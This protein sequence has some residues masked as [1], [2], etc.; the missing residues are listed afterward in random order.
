MGDIEKRIT[1]K[2]ILDSTGFNSSIKGVNSELKN[3]QSALKLASSSLQTFG[4]DSEKLKSVQEALSKQIELQSKKIDIYKQ[5][6]EKSTSK[7]QENVAQRDKLK[8]AIDMEKAKLESA[9]QV[10]G[11]EN[12]VVT[13]LKEK[14]NT[15]TQEY[16]KADKAVESN[17]KSIQSYDTNLNKASTEMVKAQGELKKVNS[18][19]SEQNNK[20]LNSSKSLKEHS[21]G[22]KK[23]G[24]GA[25]SAGDKV[26]KLTLPL[27]AVGAAA[28][29][30]GMDFDA[31]MSRVKAISGATGEEFEKLK[32]QAI[33]LGGST[34]FSAKEAASGMENLASAGFSTSEIMSAMPGMLDL[35]AS[36]GEDLAS[37]ADIAASTLRGFGLEANQAGH[38]ADVL[39]KNAG[40]TNAAVK[41]TGEAMKY[42]APAAKSMGLGLEEVTAAIG[43]MANSGIKGSEAGTTLRGALT[44]LASPSKEAA[45]AMKDMKFEA[46]DAQGKLYSLKDLVSKL[47]VSMKGMTDQK[48]ADTIATIFGQE[49]MSGMLTL[50]EDGPEALDTLTQSYK[51]SDGAASDMAKTMQD[52]AKSSIEQMFGS[53]ET[54]GI[55]LEESFAPTITKVAETIGDLADKFSQLSPETQDGIVKMVAFGLATGGVLKVVGGAISTI[56][57]IAGGVSKL[58]GIL[59]TA[60]V[61]TEGV[62]TAGAVA[63][64]V[65]GATGLGA[66]AT[67]LGGAVIA[68]APYIAVAGAVALAGYGIYKGLTQEVVPS[69]DLFADK[70][71]YTSTQVQG[72]YG[73][74]ATGVQ[75]NT[76]K[77]SEAT[78]TAVQGYLDMDEGAKSYLQDLYINGQVITD[79][80][81]TDSKTKFDDMKNS[82]VQGYETQKTDSLTK[83]QELFTS[84]STLTDTEQAEIIQKTTDFY[85]NKQT[86]T[87]QY[88]DQINQIIKG[89]SDAK[90][91]LTEEEVTTISGLQNQMR[92]NAV[93]SLSQNETEAAVILQRM[94]DYDGRITAEQA[95]E[96]IKKL[97]E[98]RDGAVQA[99]NDEYDKN[100]ATITKMR[101]ETG[102]ISAEQADKMIAE[103]KRQRDEVVQHAEDTRTNAVEKIKGMN[104]D[105]ENNVDTTSGKILTW[106]D[107]LKKWWGSWQPEQKNFS[108]NTVE[109]AS[110]SHSIAE[111]DSNWT[112][113]ESFKGGLTTLHEKGYELYDLP[114]KTRIYNHEASEAL[115]LKTAESVASKVANSIA[116]NSNSNSN[117]QPIVVE[118]PVILDGQEIA[119]VSTPYISEQLAFIDSRG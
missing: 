35:A 5:S 39:A 103:A 37:S 91:T 107:K 65:G 52:N 102:T 47:Q 83:L 85:T 111:A 59:G 84:Q 68:A 33:D 31:Q 116:Q 115:V 99:A 29:K 117:S 28:A 54:A 97:N 101:D 113:N 62:A 56:G 71:T 86:Q 88:E 105:I 109:T 6:M 41:D 98:S 110:G 57:T 30:V 26:L 72:Q 53:L 92:E 51:N 80:I 118:V 50:I 22:L 13:N 66:L 18:E 79:Q 89:A 69:V 21:E 61:A 24:E 114:Q 7:M 40:A 10:Y 94:K 19:L 82:I 8:S 25:S 4:K 45:T 9:I 44:R 90:R 95:S 73:Q 112:G 42:V 75:T 60:T 104:T 87:Q 81:T 78:K 15:L 55:K 67:G 43:E 48:K 14:I 38:V 93:N 58:A 119:R 64:G 34:A 27:V 17:A 20:W 36:S 12:Q 11:K 46:F 76:T 1:A 32:N 3:N 2:Y 100:I 23:V 106:W 16:T 70:V 49:A 108:Y 63:G 74:M 77:I 96:H